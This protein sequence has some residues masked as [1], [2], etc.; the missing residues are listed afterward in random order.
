MLELW[1]LRYFRYLCYRQ[2]ADYKDLVVKD[3]GKIVMGTSDTQRESDGES[4]IQGTDVVELRSLLLM[5]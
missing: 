4:I 5:C 3:K 1:I 2:T